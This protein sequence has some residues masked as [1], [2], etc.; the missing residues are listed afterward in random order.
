MGY[1]DNYIETIETRVNYQLDHFFTQKR[2]LGRLIDCRRAG[3]GAPSN[4]AAMRVQHPNCLEL[5]LNLIL[6]EQKAVRKRKDYQLTGN[7][8]GS[9]K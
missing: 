2:F 6:E 4:H 7:F 8:S 3:D 1:L 5:N 9:R